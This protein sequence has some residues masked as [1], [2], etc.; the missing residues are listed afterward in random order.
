MFCSD[1]LQL[2]VPFSLLLPELLRVILRA[3]FVVGLLVIVTVFVKV[4][5][6]VLFMRPP[7]IRHHAVSEACL[8]M[9][10]D[11]RF[12]HQKGVWQWRLK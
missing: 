5:V 3:V 4:F 9:R 10:F 8:S 2:R 7:L 11:D 6:T 12:V 1:S